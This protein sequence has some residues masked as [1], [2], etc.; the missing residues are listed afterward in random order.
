MAPSS[1]AGSRS[2]HQRTRHTSSV[3][4]AFLHRLSGII[5]KMELVPLPRIRH[6]NVPMNTAF[7]IG[8]RWLIEMRQDS[9]Q[10]Q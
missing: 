9:G 1:A 7:R 8:G 3:P 2:H 6:R 5:N 10:T 4:L